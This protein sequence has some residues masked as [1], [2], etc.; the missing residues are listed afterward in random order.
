[1]SAARGE[2][3]AGAPG[4]PVEGRDTT[5]GG[6]S[7]HD[8]DQEC[9]SD[10][11]YE[12]SDSSDD[13][14]GDDAEYESTDISDEE[15]SGGDLGS[16]AECETSDDSDDD[17]N[18]D[19]G[20]QTTPTICMLVSHIAWRLAG[21]YCRYSGLPLRDADRFVSDA[22]EVFFGPR[23]S[24]YLDAMTF[25]YGRRSRRGTSDDDPMSTL[26][27]TAYM[28]M[29]LWATA[30]IALAKSLA[31]IC[32]GCRKGVCDVQD[33]NGCAD[34]VRGDECGLGHDDDCRH[35]KGEQHGN[36]M[37]YESAQLANWRVDDA[38][39]ICGGWT[40]FIDAMRRSRGVRDIV[41]E[42]N[43]RSLSRSDYEGDITIARMM[44][45][46]I[47]SNARHASTKEAQ[48]GILGAL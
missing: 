34:D 8:V 37:I 33:A 13:D 16:D 28:P 20:V 2:L 21:M 38:V 32:I 30:G 25:A 31:L 18:S 6:E 39:S 26:A 44:L 12:S 4:T 29:M 9:D 7:K 24:E 46:R 10:S 41:A 19:D 22:A 14:F 47:Q 5:A 36:S 17:S 40:Q 27:R 11:E 1:M 15:S 42:E 3:R 35:C 43:M 48:N 45:W 23:R